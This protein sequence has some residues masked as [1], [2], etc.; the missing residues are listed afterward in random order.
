VDKIAGHIPTWKASMLERSG[1]LILIDSSIVAT[2][3][4]HMLYLDLP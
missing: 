2:P 3:I 4:Y 1:R